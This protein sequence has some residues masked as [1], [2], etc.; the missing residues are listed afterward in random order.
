M[1]R[2]PAHPLLI[3]ALALCALAQAFGSQSGLVLCMG[4]DDNA[5][6]ARIGQDC[7]DPCADCCPGDDEPPAHAYHEPCGCFDVPL[8]GMGDSGSR[9][10]QWGSAAAPTLAATPAPLAAIHVVPQASAPPISAR[11]L[12]PPAQLT[13]I[14]RST[15]LL[16]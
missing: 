8:A 3:L 11:A 13:R 6:W 9:I 12:G 15:I 7:A 16:V 5:A 4:C 2:A 14:T 1:R 10:G